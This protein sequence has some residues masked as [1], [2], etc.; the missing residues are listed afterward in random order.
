MF[1]ISHVVL[2]W[3]L[4]QE[5]SDVT[6]KNQNMCTTF[7]LINLIERFVYKWQDNIKID[8]R[9]ISDKDLKRMNLSNG[10]RL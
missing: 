1:C 7:T 5:A 6:C 3:R 2:L 10:E 8:H 9:N 4:D